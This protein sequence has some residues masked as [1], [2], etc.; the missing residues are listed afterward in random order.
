MMRPRR[1]FPFPL[2]LLA[3]AALTLPACT[4][5]GTVKASTDMTSD[6]T[7]TTSGKTWFTEDGLV[8]QDLKLVAFV[9]ANF[10]NLKQD[11]ARGEGEYVASLGTLLAVPSE[12]RAEFAAFTRE[13]YAMLIRS[14]QTTPSQMLAALAQSWR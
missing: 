2:L 1:V 12:R 14:E 10:E 3:A 7:V 6:V 11:M 13:R 9:T 8:K 4:I 5:K